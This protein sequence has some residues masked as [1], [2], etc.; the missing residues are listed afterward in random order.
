MNQ[1]PFFFVA[2]LGALLVAASV[3]RADI[4]ETKSG[5]RLIGKVT[6]ID[7]STVTLSTDYAGSLSVKQSEVVSVQTDAPLFVRLSGGTVMEGTVAPSEAG[8]IQIKGGDGTITTSVDKIAATWAPGSPDPAVVALERKWSYEA[9]ADVNGKSGNSE[10]LGTAFAFRAQQ[11][12]PHDKLKLYTAYNRQKT[13]GAVSA[14]QLKAGIDYSNNFSGRTSWYVRDEGGYDH[15][16][17]ISSYNTSAAGFGY[18]FIQKPL[19][20][21]TGRAGLSF[22]Y[23]DYKNPATQDVQDVGLD[24]GVH[25]E[26]TFSNSKLVNNLSYT[27]SFNDTSDF[28]FEHESY[29]EIPLVDLKWKIRIGLSHDYN[30]KPGAG[31]DRLDTTYFTRLVLDWE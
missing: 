16:K 3:A 13:D 31:V 17:D 28:H 1:K 18:D 24:F 15:V 26:Y 5:A 12:G 9:T 29:Y 27:P 7:G 11:T 23:E 19:H 4:I 20:L 6:K 21:L 25:H 2:A 10:Q 8:K 14:D 22:R 30:S